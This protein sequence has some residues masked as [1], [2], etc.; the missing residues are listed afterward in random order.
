VVAP[1]I[2]AFDTGTGVTAL[3][4]LVGAQILATTSNADVT[5]GSAPGTLVRF[6]FD[7]ALTGNPAF[8]RFL[9]YD[10]THPES[11]SVGADGP[12]SMLDPVDPDAVLVNFPVLTSQ[13]AIVDITIVGVEAGAVAGE[14]GRSN[15]DGA[16]AVGTLHP[17]PAAPGTTKAPDARLI[18]GIRPAVAPG[19]SAL[20]VLFD[21][22]AFD[23][24]SG[25]TGAGVSVVFSDGSGARVEA[26]CEPPA[27]GNVASSGGSVPGGDGTTVWTVLCPDDPNN[28]GAVLTPS[29]LGRIVIQPDVVGTAPPGSDGDVLAQYG[30]AT[31]GQRHSTLTPDLFGA[32]LL[33]TTAFGAQDGIAVTFDQAVI[34]PAVARFSAVMSD[35]SAVPALSAASIPG[36]GHAVIIALPAGT[37]ADAVGIAVVSGAV[38]TPT[39]VSNVDDEIGAFNTLSATITPGLTAGPGLQSAALRP[40]VGSRGTP[41]AEAA[42]LTFSGPL[43]GPSQPALGQIHAY[44]GDGTELTCAAAPGEAANGLDQSDDP[45]PDAVAPATL[46]CDDWSLGTGAIGPAARIAN[47]QAI[48]LVTVDPL[49]V[50]DLESRFNP[51]LAVVASGGDGVPL[52]G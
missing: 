39:S 48:V 26:S 14:D 18:V 30:E 8:S 17:S 49:T 15:P 29:Q 7:E 46:Q 23:Q 4:E 52:A 1:V 37:D 27:P 5:V 51:V 42:L 45:F 16:F 36:N 31:T 34:A 11:P 20:D 9:A 12:A 3:P 35:G 32:A 21:K 43:A 28:P 40:L 6:I 13:A 44:D 22:P 2:T 50:A 38:S 10:S 47:Q 25:S 19:I 41:I 33:P 24:S